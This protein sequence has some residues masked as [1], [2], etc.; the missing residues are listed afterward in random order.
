MRL[1]AD[2]RTCERAGNILRSAP[3]RFGL[4]VEGLKVTARC[5]MHNRNTFLM[6]NAIRVQHAKLRFH[7][8]AVM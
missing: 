5:Y 7:H 6:L 1:S 4:R 2:N 3:G 8:N